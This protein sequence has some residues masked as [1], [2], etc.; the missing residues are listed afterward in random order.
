MYGYHG[1]AAARDIHSVDDII[2]HNY[3][4]WGENLQKDL[5]TL[6]KK[7]ELENTL[8]SESEQDS[9]ISFLCKGLSKSFIANKSDVILNI[10]TKRHLLSEKNV[11]RIIKCCGKNSKYEWI[12]SLVKLGYKISDKQQ[13][14]IIVNGY[15]KGIIKML[16]QETA[17]YDDLMI[18]CKTAPY[19]ITHMGKFLSKFKLIPT[20]E[21]L[22]TAITA[23]S[24]VIKSYSK[25][26]GI[27]SVYLDD[28]LMQFL[29]HGLEFNIDLLLYIMQKVHIKP[30][31]NIELHV[32]TEKLIISNSISLNTFYN[33]L[34]LKH[35]SDMIIQNCHIII[36]IFVRNNLPLNNDVYMHLMSTSHYNNNVYVRGKPT[37]YTYDNDKIY[38]TEMAKC[39]DLLLNNCIPDVKHVEHA[40]L[41]GD[42]LSFDKMYQKINTFTE[43]CLINACKSTSNNILTKSLA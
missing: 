39:L 1:H 26:I 22:Q 16:D 33:V 35:Q 37:T 25:Y 31:V 7:L 27:A 36:E 28:V 9:L 18:L 15:K 42:E 30:S 12:E 38:C 14:E 19:N 20:I 5:E 23:N 41:M 2:H 11:T 6:F 24:F 13:A 8:L 10:I 34:S 43:T 4:R 21:H 17:T 3:S 40:C 29:N 32:Y